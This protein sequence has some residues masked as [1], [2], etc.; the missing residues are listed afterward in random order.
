MLATLAR[1]PARVSW[2]R[3]DWIFRDAPDVDSE[4]Y[5]PAN[6][7]RRN[8]RGIAEYLFSGAMARESLW[9]LARSTPP[10][11]KTVARLTSGI[12]VK[13]PIAEVDDINVLTP[14]FDVGGFYNAK[15]ACRVP[16]HHRPRAQPLSRGGLWSMRL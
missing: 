2:Q 6:L 1:N 3:D 8:A 7:Y 9:M 4:S 12:I 13:F 11:Q 14:V 15:F 16:A 10:L 5:F